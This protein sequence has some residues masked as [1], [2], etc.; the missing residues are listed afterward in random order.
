MCHV[1]RNIA[2]SVWAGYIFAM[3]L[4]LILI[5]YHFTD[6][7][8]C[9]IHHIATNI[10]AVAFDICMRFVFGAVCDKYGARIPMGTVLMLASIP[11][12][13]IG[14]VNSLTGL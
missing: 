8:F 4:F 13:C 12:A 6:N 7:T 11:T 5:L 1:C 2:G 14:L 3:L 10:F 9:I